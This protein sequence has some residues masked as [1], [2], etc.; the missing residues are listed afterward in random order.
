M[1]RIKPEYMNKSKKKN[2]LSFFHFFIVFGN[3][4]NNYN[5]KGNGRRA[6]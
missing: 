4:R 2:S 3:G 5:D 1:K 6:L